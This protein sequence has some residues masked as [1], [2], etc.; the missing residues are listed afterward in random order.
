M[1][2]RLDGIKYFLDSQAVKNPIWNPD[3]ETQV[4]V[5]PGTRD[6]SQTAKGMLFKD[7]TTGESWYN[8]RIPKNAKSSDFVFV[9]KSLTFDL[10]RRAL[11]IGSTGWNWRRRISEWVGYDFDSIANH[12]KGHS[13][14]VLSEV[15]DKLKSIP[16][17][18]IRKSKSGHGF[19]VFVFIEGSPQVNNHNEHAALARAILQQMSGL[20]GFNFSD[21]VDCVGQ[22]MWLW[23]RN[24]Q[25]GAYEVVKASSQKFTQIPPNWQDHTSSAT[26]KVGRRKALIDALKRINGVK[27][28]DIKSF[29]D[30]HSRS[31]F[32]ALTEKHRKLVSA[33]TEQN[34]GW[35]DADHNCLVTHTKVLEELKV[36]LGLEGLFFTIAQGR[37]AN[38]W[39]CFC[40]PSTQGWTI[41][42]YTKGC[43]EHASWDK[44]SNGWTFCRF[45]CSP[46]FEVVARAFN[47]ILGKRSD[48][49]FPNLTEAGKALASLGF[50]VQFDPVMQHK[51][52]TILYKKD[53]LILEVPYEARDNTDHMKQ[54]RRE[55]ADKPKKWV[56]VFKF[57]EDKGTQE[58]DT[59]D[60]ILRGARFQGNF[61]G[62]FF[63]TTDG[64]WM[65]LDRANLRDAIG[66]YNFESSEVANM[67]GAALATPWKVVTEPFQP[68]YPGDRVWNRGAAQLAYEPKP[69]KH[70]FWDRILEHMGAGLDDAIRIQSPDSAAGKWL[71]KYGV[72]NGAQYLK[73]WLACC[74]QRPKESLPYLSFYS[75]QEGTGKSTFHEMLSTLFVKGRGYVKAEQAV[76]SESNFNG[77]LH[78][79]L[80]CIIEE[81]NLNNRKFS[82]KVKDWVT[83][84][85]ITI[86]AKNA[87]PYLVENYTHWMQ[88]SNNPDYTPLFDGDTRIVM[89]CVPPIPEADLIDGFKLYDAILA[90]N[91]AFLN[92]LLTMPLPD[93]C[94]RLQIPVLVTLEKQAT[95]EAKA[96]PLDV[97]IKERVFAI[98]GALTNV[99]DFYQAFQLYLMQKY[100]NNVASE[101]T[102]RKIA[103][104]VPRSWLKG[105]NGKERKTYY[106][107]LSLDEAV[108]PGTPWRVNNNQE[109]VR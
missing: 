76:K 21:G 26:T 3:L 68:E 82:D 69:G 103:A 86:H 93:R 64:E 44:D 77:E 55:P 102:D 63:R 30:L 94:G 92:T 75:V 95:M 60:N 109:L 83:G 70:P 43:E 39:N 74:F 87:T 5:V 31:N 15:M 80:L 85:Y 50:S 100:D 66:Y 98:D 58:L 79:A 45:D 18:S 101:W 56:R 71:L 28:E 81:V 2:N 37:Q 35:W 97:F 107:N 23:H 91:P 27:E 40:M 57:R 61:E 17:T 12:T 42:R 41:R 48:Y 78:G 29:V 22:N 106:G 19:H 20:A 33:V 53:M 1:L 32:C 105:K 24:A 62:F 49:E 38:D 10:S 99:S 52:A 104:S 8:F 90:E 7:P 14:E 73:Y 6:P 96:S 54:W 84:R 108:K 89:V 88:F 11:G 13:V 9:N 46:T 34:L 47:G 25:P 4:N 65:A 72:T 16:W 51:Q 59:Y 67:I 36:K